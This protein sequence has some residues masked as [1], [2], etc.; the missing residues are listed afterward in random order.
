M[1]AAHDLRFFFLNNFHCLS[2]LQLSS[3]F[4]EFI[5]HFQETIRL[6]LTHISEEKIDIIVKHW[7]N[8][9]R[10][11]NP[12]SVNSTLVLQEIG[13]YK[14]Q[15]NCLALLHN[16]L[17]KVCNGT[18][19]LQQYLNVLLTYTQKLPPRQLSITANLFGNSIEPYQRAIGLRCL[20]K[21]YFTTDSNEMG[22]QQIV[23][24]CLNLIEELYVQSKTNKGF[25]LYN[26]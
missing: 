13:P 3:A 11:D 2:E 23:N 4:E 26:E 9:E 5:L 21:N 8:A 10:L 22:D 17:T 6:F 20:L 25:L 24:E 14:D 7:I 15:E 19:N 1:V 16:D 18:D 12:F